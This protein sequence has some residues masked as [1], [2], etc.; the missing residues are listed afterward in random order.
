LRIEEW[1]EQEKYSLWYKEGRLGTRAVGEPAGVTG[2]A[3]QCV[4]GNLW[5]LDGYLV[6]QG[7]MEVL[8]VRKR[9]WGQWSRR[10]EE[11]EVG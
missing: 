9:R 10:Y 7:K 8:S 11:K 4:S 2:P 1:T 6:S 3:C 5:S